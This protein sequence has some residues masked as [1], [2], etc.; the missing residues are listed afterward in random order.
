MRAV[1][2]AMILVVAAGWSGA[3][4]AL[5]P[6]PKGDPRLVGRWAAVQAFHGK[7][8]AT[9]NNRGLEYEFRADGTWVVRRD[10]NEHLAAPGRYAVVPE[11]I[12]AAIDLFPTPADPKGPVLRGVYKVERDTLTLHIRQGADRPTGFEATDTASL[13]MLIRMRAD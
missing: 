3:A 12:P 6:P 2:L 5:K 1:G 8:D 4:P 11:S 10:G 7:W 9:R 13:I